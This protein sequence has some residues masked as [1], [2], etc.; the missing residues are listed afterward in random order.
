MS[1]A[2]FIQWRGTSVT[3][4]KVTPGAMNS[5]TGVAA[6]PTESSCAGNAMELSGDFSKRYESLGL[7]QQDIRTVE[8]I[9]TTAGT[10]PA[11]G[12]TGTWAGQTFTVAKS[13]PSTRT[14]TAQALRLI[15][16]R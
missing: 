2:G 16:A 12:A 13:D 14:G 9:P 7:T 10:E 8:F 3:W 4:T 11:L 6:A 5:G 1:R 15:I